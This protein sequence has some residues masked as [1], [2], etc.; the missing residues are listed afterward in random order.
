[1]LVKT[2]SKSALHIE[3]NEQWE[4][5]M[6]RLIGTQFGVNPLP[7]Y[8]LL[9]SGKRRIRI[10]SEEA[11][12][13]VRLIPK[14]EVAGLYLGELGPSGIRLSLDGSQLIGPHA[15]KQIVSLTPAQAE[16]W[17]RGE[18]ID[19]KDSHRGYVIVRHQSDILGCGS[20]FGGRLHNFL[21]KD[22]RPQKQ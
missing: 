4:A 14:P 5:E 16:A 19:I 13:L 2:M 10:V 22:R 8:R 9:R 15:T 21:P 18:S 17:L 20:L 12:Q 6:W 11:Y 7:G 1:M 3:G